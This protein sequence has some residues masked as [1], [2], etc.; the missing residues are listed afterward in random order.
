MIA[1]I[2][3]SLVWSACIALTWLAV[4]FALSLGSFSN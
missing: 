4:W 3:D 1:R 2:A